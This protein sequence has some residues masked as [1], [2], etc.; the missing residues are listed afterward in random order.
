MRFPIT[1]KLNASEAVRKAFELL[2]NKYSV[3]VIKLTDHPEIALNGGALAL[4]AS[5]TDHHRSRNGFMVYEEVHICSFGQKLVLIGF[6]EK[7]GSYPGDEFAYDIMAF[8]IPESDLAEPDM[9]V[10]LANQIDH[11]NRSFSS[12]L[13]IVMSD[14]RLILANNLL[15]RATENKL[16]SFIVHKEEKHAIRFGGEKVLLGHACHYSGEF[17][18]FLAQELSFHLSD[19]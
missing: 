18:R 17:P 4:I 9:L 11:R 19:I 1:G 12:S 10:N 14:G 8:S 5:D 7:T 6:G 16:D 13:V 15:R 3:R 2:V